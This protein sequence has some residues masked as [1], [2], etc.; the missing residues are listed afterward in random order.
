MF[1]LVDF[2]QFQYALLHGD[3]EKIWSL[4]YYNEISNPKC[5]AL[6][7]ENNLKLPLPMALV[8]AHTSGNALYAI[9]EC[10]LI[11]N[12]F[13][14]FECRRGKGGAVHNCQHLTV[15]KT[16]FL[17]SPPQKVYTSTFFK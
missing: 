7:A 11:E 5:R 9:T 12:L 8:T 16:K 2:I 10:L 6:S 3:H 17:R 1:K 15:Y 14:K 4:L 13:L